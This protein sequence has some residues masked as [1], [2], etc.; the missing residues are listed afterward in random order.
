MAGSMHMVLSRS[1]MAGVL[2]GVVALSGC[3]TSAP[4]PTKASME[5]NA[6]V[7]SVSQ[8]DEAATHSKSPLDTSKVVLWV[9]GLGCPQCAT[10]ADL[11]LKRIRAVSGVR[12]DLGQG[13]IYVDLLGKGAKPSPHDFSEA[14]LDAGFTLV[15]IE[16][17]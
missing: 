14:I 6:V 4:A 7:H 3:A 15:K 9:N 16:S 17:L 1:L 13:K 10:N 5:E 12:T 8:A 2:G 11:Q